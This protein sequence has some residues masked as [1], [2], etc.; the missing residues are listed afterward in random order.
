MPKCE[1]VNRYKY[2][3][4]KSLNINYLGKIVR[5]KFLKRMHKK[6]IAQKNRRSK[7]FREKIKRLKK[8]PQK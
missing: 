2:T 5:L 1:Y 6:K 7:V 4:Y 3:N 8:S